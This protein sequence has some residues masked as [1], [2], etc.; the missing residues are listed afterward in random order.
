MGGGLV[1]LVSV[2]IRQSPWGRM[3]WAGRGSTWCGKVEEGEG[4]SGGCTE[5]GNFE[6]G[7]KWGE[8]LKTSHTRAEDAG[9]KWHMAG[10][11]ADGPTFPESHLFG[12]LQPEP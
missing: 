4:K 8:G 1:S 3:G 2:S 11:R 6:L 12:D 9:V 10:G 5:E 7:C